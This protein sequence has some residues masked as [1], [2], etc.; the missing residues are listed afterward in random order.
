ML[1]GGS[2][3]HSLLASPK[4]TT[5][6]GPGGNVSILCQPLVHTRQLQE[7]QSLLANPKTSAVPVPG[8]STVSLPNQ[9]LVD[10]KQLQPFSAINKLKDTSNTAPLPIVPVFPTGGKEENA[11]TPLFSAATD[12]SAQP[13]N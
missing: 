3:L 13:G 6:I 8:G 2:K 11:V 7:L 9:P 10:T 12:S 5:V 4:T 1:G